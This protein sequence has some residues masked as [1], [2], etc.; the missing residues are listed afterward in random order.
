[1]PFVPFSL[2]HI[3]II[4][5]G[6]LILLAVMYY[7][8]NK[9]TAHTYK[10]D[11]MIYTLLMAGI[12]FLLTITK[13]LQ[14]EWTIQGNLPLHLCDI[15]AWTLVYALWSKN[16]L[17]FQAGYYWGVLGAL[18]AFLLPNI[19]KVDWY[20]IP[21]FVWHVLLAAAPLYYIFTQKQYPTQKGLWQT[22][23]L[24]LALGL[25]IKMINAALDSNYMFVSKRIDAMT[26]VG[27]PDYPYYLFMLFPVVIGLYYIFWLPFGK[28]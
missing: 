15:S 6:I 28:K 19:T 22:A 24:T 17:A 11:V 8:K 16:N 12:Y 20:M 9:A 7:A 3:T 10:R 5:G 26:W 18:L 13:L 21:F 23:G 27:L 1:M 2:I 25:V 4:V 14:K